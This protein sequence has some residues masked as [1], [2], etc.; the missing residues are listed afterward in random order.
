MELYRNEKNIWTN[1]DDFMRRYNERVPLTQSQ[2]FNRSKIKY[3]TVFRWLIVE[4]SER[5]IFWDNIRRDHANGNIDC[6]EG[7]LEEIVKSCTDVSR[8][9]WKNQKG[10]VA[11]SRRTQLFLSDMFKYRRTQK[12]NGSESFDNQTGSFAMKV[13]SYVKNRVI[14]QADNQIGGRD[15]EEALIYAMAS[16]GDYFGTGMMRY[17]ERQIYKKFLKVVNIP[18]IARLDAELM[19]DFKFYA[20]FFSTICNKDEK[21]LSKN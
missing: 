5:D 11:R 15:W 8:K 4:F 20:R 21:R 2:I 19:L 10:I 13:L 12:C 17:N 1:E 3:E 7:R 18:P 14:S 9:Y 16:N 6:Y